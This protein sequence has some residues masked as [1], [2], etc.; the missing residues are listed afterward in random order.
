M[1]TFFQITYWLS[2]GALVHS[3]ILYPFLMKILA[4][5]RR[6]NNEIYSDDS[7]DL[8]MV[9]V[10]MS[11][12][13]EDK[14]IGEKLKSLANIQYPSDKLHIFIGSDG[15]NDATNLIC[16]D[17][18]RKNANFRFE[19]FTLRR[20]KP[21]VVNDLVRMAAAKNPIGT[22][23]I[24]VLTDA[25]VMLTQS[26]IFKL[27]RHFKN[28][29]IGVVDAHMR[30]TGIQEEGISRSENQYI[31]SETILKHHESVVLGQMIGPFGGCY[32]LRSDLF[33]EV[34]LNFLVDD[35]YITFRVLE[36]GF[37]AIN[38]LEAACYEGSTHEVKDEYKR[39]K[40]IAAGSF[41]NLNVFKKWILP[42]FTTLGFA[43]FSHKVLR[44]LG[45][46]FILIS[47]FS[48]GFLAFDNQFYLILFGLMTLVL[49][50]I[51]I[52]NWIFTRLNI[53]VLLFKN[54]TYLLAMNAALVAGFFKYWRGIHENTWQRTKRY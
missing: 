44:W 52:A 53:H 45:G 6:K 21:P 16:K 3:Y 35:F 23:H 4:R 13:N 47:Y 54:W 41:Q 32:A 26:V 42:P 20:G 43:F 24:F 50:G 12:Y 11:L 9:S 15:S 1:T 5:G 36:Q 37:E 51:P 17:F 48:A 2:I 14:V 8:P 30:A 10:I 19:A 39:K 31:S 49:I 40:R 34:P 28:P 25:S 7:P 27:V 46:F 38:D 29:K 18:E 33:S 22:N